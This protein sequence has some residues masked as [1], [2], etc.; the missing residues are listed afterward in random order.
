MELLKGVKCWMMQA[1]LV[2]SLLEREKHRLF[3]KGFEHPRYEFGRILVC[4]LIFLE[5]V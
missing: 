1:V 3:T 5:R 4:V 2:P